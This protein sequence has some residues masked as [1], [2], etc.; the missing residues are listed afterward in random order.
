MIHTEPT[1]TSSPRTE[2]GG[3]EP[4]LAQCS[5][6]QLLAPLT[7]AVCW[8]VAVFIVQ[9]CTAGANYPLPV[10]KAVGGRVVRF[11]LDFLACGTITFLLGGRGATIAILETSNC[12]CRASREEP[13]K[14]LKEVAIESF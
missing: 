11:S 14:P 1:S 2:Q 12:E 7:L 9:E 13:P 3:L 10:S 4:S 8:A 6:K 5:F